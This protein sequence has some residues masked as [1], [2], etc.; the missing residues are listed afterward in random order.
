MIHESPQ[1]AAELEAELAPLVLPHF[2]EPTAYH[3]GSILVRRAQEGRMP[4]VINIRNANR[5]F[6]HAALPGSAATNDNWARRK[7]NTA[8]MIGKA[9]LVIGRKYAEIGRTLD[10]DG[11]PAADY[12]DS[13]GAVPL[14]VQGAGMVAVCTVS[15]LPQVEDHKLVLAGLRE[16]LAELT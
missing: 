14:I 3:L 9:S 13:G 5:T 6:F 2:D 7:S 8:L 4:V 1:T 16:L 15:G 11:L 10:T 12:A